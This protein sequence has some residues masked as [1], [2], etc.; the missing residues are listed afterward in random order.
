M[1]K[2]VFTV[3]GMKCEH[4][5]ANVEKAVKAVAGVNS[6]KADRSANNITVDA[7][8]S[9]KDTDIQVAVNDLGRYELVL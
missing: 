8:D 7:D 3:N 5:E 1:A 4:C 6:V 2:K 9:V